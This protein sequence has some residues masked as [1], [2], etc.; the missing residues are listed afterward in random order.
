MATNISA[1][2]GSG[3]IVKIEVECEYSTLAIGKLD[4]LIGFIFC[5]R[6]DN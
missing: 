4:Y 2:L 3:K 6:E 5:R 1:S